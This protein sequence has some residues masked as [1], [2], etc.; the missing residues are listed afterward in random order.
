MKASPNADG[1]G[2]QGLT[3]AHVGLRLTAAFETQTYTLQPEVLH[4]LAIVSKS[5]KLL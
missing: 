2:V 4:C 1:N 5:L 3:M